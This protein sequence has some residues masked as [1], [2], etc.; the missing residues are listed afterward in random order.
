MRCQ[1]VPGVNMRA[2]F[3]WRHFLLGKTLTWLLLYQTE[4][5][6]MQP[7]YE[8]IWHPKEPDIMMTSGTLLRAT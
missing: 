5:V 1:T 4:I 7:T 2:F 8:G 6:K 3:V